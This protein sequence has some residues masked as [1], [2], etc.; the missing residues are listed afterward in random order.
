M[1]VKENRFNIGKYF[2][3]HAFGIFV[4]VFCYLLSSATTVI[5]TLVAAE[6]LTHITTA[7]YP[8]AF[9]FLLYSAGIALANE[10]LYLI[11]GYLATYLQVHI[12]NAM[13]VDIAE[14]VFKISSKSYSDHNTS[15]FTRRISY[16]PSNLF[17]N[18]RM[19]LDNMSDIISSA[20]ITIYICT[21]NIWV[22]LLMIGGLAVGTIVEKFRKRVYVKNKKITHKSNEKVNSLLNE[23]VR[24]ERDIKSLNLEQ[25]LKN[26]IAK[27]YED[28]QKKQLKTDF[29]DMG[30]FRI[31]NLIMAVLVLGVLWL[32][33]YL[34]EKALLTFTAFMII[35]S[36]RGS[37]RMLVWILGR[38]S[39]YVTEIKL[40]FGRINELYEN[41]EYELETFGKRK[42][43]NVKGSIKFDKVAYTYIDMKLNP[44][45]EKLTA[46]QKKTTPKYIESGRNKIFHNLNFEI[47]PNSTVAFVG[48]SGSGKSTILN[49]ISKMYEVDSGKVLIDGVNINSLNKQTIRSSIALVNQFPYIFDMTIKENLLM[50]RPNATDEQITQALKDSA[51]DE[52]IATLEDGINTRVGESG[53]KLSGGQKQRLAIARALLKESSI[54][55]FDESTSSLDNIA[56]QQV[57]QSIDNIKGKSTIVIV[58]HRLST[59]KNVDKIFFLED[60]KI[61]DQGTFEELYER[62]SA[63]KT[64]F[65]AENI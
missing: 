36:N 26:E 57:K 50:V 35:Y 2:K 22:G 49:L 47:E 34:M 32:G 17:V 58:A 7:N 12:T 20:V 46:K 39:L 23:V 19:I 31:R 52:F 15:N 48:K 28:Y 62:N 18:I 51:L 56:Q 11:I 61:M 53:I 29:T 24:S 37:L 21:V 1:K 65:L 30:F 13:S 25:P 38:L 42:L 4:V 45:Y 59:I 40:S 9:R 6:F 33:A 63:F 5:N 27:K 41:D 55:L 8:L 3:R 60:G 43:K 64:I 10:L 44:E 54:I 16:D 14:Q